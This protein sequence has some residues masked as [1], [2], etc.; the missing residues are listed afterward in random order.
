MKHQTAADNAPPVFENITQDITVQVEP[1][2]T[3]A[4]VTWT[5]PVAT[6]ASGDVTLTSNHNPGDIFPVGS[7][8]VN[9]MAVD[10][11]GNTA[12]LSFIVKVIG[13]YTV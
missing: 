2:E 1:G 4:L 3:Q 11:T 10:L 8:I 5:T 7:T 12:S 9:Y 13:E 6:D